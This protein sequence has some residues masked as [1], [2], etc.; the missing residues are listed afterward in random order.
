[1]NKTIRSAG[2]I[3]LILA[4][5]QTALATEPE[6]Q[7]I[8]FDQVPVTTGSANVGDRTLL[9]NLIPNKPNHLELGFV[10]VARIDLDGKGS[11]DLLG[12]LVN[13][14]Y[15][16]GHQ[17]S[18]CRLFAVVNQALITFRCLAPIHGPIEV[19]TTR[20]NGL[21]D[22][23]WQPGCRLKYNGKQFYDTE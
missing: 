4:L 5:I 10:R 18:Q 7:T 22:I 20:T 14:G 17:Q 16:C 1:M 2:V 21:R 13:N 6:F 23:R 9:W 15:F 3:L 11:P 12:T 19:L 8:Q